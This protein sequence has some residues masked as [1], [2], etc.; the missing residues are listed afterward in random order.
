MVTE[1]AR[2]SRRLTD[3]DI[4]GQLQGG[5]VVAEQARTSRRLTDDEIPTLDGIEEARW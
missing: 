1:P 3:D 5:A 4:P 2:T